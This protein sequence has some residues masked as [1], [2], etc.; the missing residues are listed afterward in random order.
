MET[1]RTQRGLSAAARDN[2][3]KRERKVERRVDDGRRLEAVRRPYCASRQCNQHQRR[4]NA[5]DRP[6]RSSRSTPS[7]GSLARR[8][9]F[10]Q[11]RDARLDG[12]HVASH[13]VRHGLV[14]ATRPRERG[15]CATEM[16]LCDWSSDVCSSDLRGMGNRSLGCRQSHPHGPLQR[17]PIPWAVCVMVFWRRTSRALTALRRL[18]HPPT[19]RKP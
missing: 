9:A 5:E 16:N 6:A 19:P 10:R 2:P 11:F 12:V 3:G 15:V 4:Q 17:Q 8:G 7:P 13:I 14:G 18:W 1:E